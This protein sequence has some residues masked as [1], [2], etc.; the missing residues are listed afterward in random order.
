MLLKK[1]N[2][3]KKTIVLVALGEYE[4]YFR[5]M[6]YGCIQLEAL[7][8]N[9]LELSN[10]D[11]TR[12]KRELREQSVVRGLELATW[13]RIGEGGVGGVRGGMRGGG[14]GGV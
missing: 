5:C 11:L 10:L 2:N 8:G 3:K 13:W 12:L 7:G 9:T 14:V 4:S 1:K 6:K